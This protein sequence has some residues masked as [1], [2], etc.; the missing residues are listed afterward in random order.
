MLLSYKT[1]GSHIHAKVEFGE[2]KDEV[3]LDKIEERADKG[4]TSSVS[5]V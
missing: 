4:Y 3:L 2:G 1:S 5:T